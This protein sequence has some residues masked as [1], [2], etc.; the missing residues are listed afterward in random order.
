ML[1]LQELHRARDAGGRAAGRLLIWRALFGA[2]PARASTPRPRTGSARAALRGGAGPRPGAARWP[3]ALR[4]R[5]ATRRCACARS[6]STCRARSAWPPA[7]T[8]TPRTVDALGALG[9]GFVEVGTVTAQAAARQPAPADVPAARRPRAGQPHGLQQRRGAGRRRRRGSAPAGGAGVVVGV[10]IGRTKVARRG[11][12]AADYRASAAALAPHA[13]YLVLNV[14]SPNTPGLRDL[15]AVEHARAADRRGARGAGRGRPAGLP[16]LVKIAPDL[17]DEDVDAIADLALRTGLD[18]LIA[19][20]TT[21][22]RDGLRTPA[23]EV[24][25]G[26]RRRPVGRAAGARARW[27][28]CGGCATRVGDRVVLV[29]VGGVQTAAEDAWSA[30]AAGATLVQ[31][32]TG[33]VY[34]GPLWPWR[35][36]RG[37]GAAGS[38]RVGSSPSPICAARRHGRVWTRTVPTGPGEACPLLTRPGLHNGPEPQCLQDRCTFEQPLARKL[39]DAPQ[40]ACKSCRHRQPG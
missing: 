29:S 30:L 5:R 22:A 34:G 40:S 1:S 32:Y 38:A 7:S 28:C 37:A 27:R 36:H 3:G 10:N 4:A 8:R 16:L 17:A 15:Q 31:A 35:V 39:A 11:R 13:D 2:G 14:S 33:F 21:I 20:N 24:A 18:G 25:G 12:P 6:A 19:T 26:R 23:A 9:F